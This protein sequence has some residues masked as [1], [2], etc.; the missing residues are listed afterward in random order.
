MSSLM[1][2]QGSGLL[3]VEGSRAIPIAS[4]LS[5]L[6]GAVPKPGDMTWRLPLGRGLAPGLPRRLFAAGGVRAALAD[7]QRYGY[8]EESRR[9]LIHTNTYVNQCS[10]TCGRVCTQAFVCVLTV[11]IHA[12]IYKPHLSLSNSFARQFLCLFLISYFDGSNLSDQ[13]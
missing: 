8:S 9:S 12:N 10:C 6:G 3:W 2:R 4:P 7:P 1:A 5:S 13:F 11:R